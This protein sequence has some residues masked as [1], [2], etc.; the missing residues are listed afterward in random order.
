MVQVKADVRDDGVV[1]H[2]KAPGARRAFGL[3]GRGTRTVPPADWSSVDKRLYEAIAALHRLGDE[4]D[5]AVRF[6]EGAVFADHRAVASLSA[7]AAHLLGLPETVPFVFA[8][9]TAGVI[10]Q[11]SFRLTYDWR[12]GGR[13][14]STRRRGAILDTPAGSF[15]IPEP[16]LSAIELSEAFE[17][18]SVDLPE[19]WAALARFRTKLDPEA[20]TDTEIVP[21]GRDLVRMA[22]ALQQM[23]IF[24]ASAF[25]LALRQ[26]GSNFQF[27]PILFDAETVEARREA[28]VELIEA[29]GVLNSQDTIAFRNDQRSGF[30]AFDQVKRTYRLGQ[31]RYVLLDGDLATV[32]QVVRDK[33][34]AAVEERR[35]F[36]ANPKPAIRE[37][38]EKQASDAGSEPDDDLVEEERIDAAA[39]AVFQETLEYIDRAIGTGLWKK[40]ELGFLP[41]ITSAWMPESFA[42]NL[43]GVWVTV[44]DNKA[45][46]VRQ[47]LIEA[48]ERGD[49]SIEFEG[50]T[51][52][53]TT[54]AVAALDEAVRARTAPPKTEPPPEPVEQTQPD[55]V[56]VLVHEN[57]VEENWNPESQPR[58]SHASDALPPTV[59]TVPMQHQQ[60]AIDWQI[61]AWKA[62]LPGILNAD[63]Q[64]LGKTFQTL[65]FLAWLRANQQSGPPSARKPIL[66]VAPTGLL[67]TWER[68]A[69]SHLAGG[70]LGELVRAYGSSLR[71]LKRHGTS[72][73]DL[74]DGQALLDFGDIEEDLERGFGNRWWVLTSYETL[75]NYQ[76]SFHKLPFA[77]A[78][79][80]EI[81]K[82]KNVQTINANAAKAVVADFRIGLTGT[83]IE[84]HI[85]DL[86][87][88]TDAIVPG[89][90]GTMRE[91]ADRYG[92]VTEAKM[93]ELHARLFTECRSTTRVLPPLAKRRLKEECIGDLP[94]KDYRI[95]PNDMPNM[96]AEVYELA[97]EKLRDGA[98]G[99]ALKLLH[100]IRSV[101]L[102]PRAPRTATN[103]PDA[104]IED[105]ARLKATFE[106]L[107]TIRAASERALVFIEDH[108]MQ[109]RVA[110]MI[111]LRYGLPQVRI[112]NG[113]TA[114]PRRQAHVEAF[115][116]HLVD[117]RG[118]DV[119]VLG[120]KAAGVGL[121]L[122]A[123]THVI[124]L[125]R[126]WNPAVEEQ[127]NDRIY[128]IGQMR[129]VT[130]HLPM[131]VHPARRHQ[132]FDCVLNTLMKRKKSL[133]R[134]VLWPP[135]ENDAD[136]S[137]LIAGLS[138]AEPVDLP[139]IDDKDWLAFEKWLVDEAERSGEWQAAQTPTSG[140]KGADV[141]LTHKQRP[142][143]FGIIQAKHTTVL[144]RLIGDDAV[145]QVL[146]ARKHWRK[147]NPQLAVVT[148]ASGFTEAAQQRARAEDVRLVDRAHLCLW[149]RHIFA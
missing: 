49:P 113:Q 38:L 143:T 35:Q 115:Q 96:Q 61:T 66:I 83:P 44:P 134:A 26:D 63:D 41:K 121:T 5:D 91:F 90:L 17:A 131:A 78:I 87:A 11:A 128:R 114:V 59:Q 100:H 138:G 70:A 99:N 81:Q 29:D 53:A 37:A 56:V 84:N 144:D 9:D 39:E 58:Q 24:T 132:S 82:I 13:S 30:E 139:S 31:G 43:D 40:P 140:D 110:E 8:A 116:R 105:S 108:D 10:G 145:R 95:Y 36:F 118:F 149:P 117:D 20:V 27:D 119:M 142:E 124:H 71:S 85:L 25:S 146:A 107:D 123:A 75:A 89:R 3:I 21:D 92:Q 125:S 6:E 106:I 23:R 147:P 42:A 73:T 80:D 86:W 57:F 67:R 15:R 60:L 47:A 50:V 120:P 69:E 94:R 1:F 93:A 18:G 28:G 2:A 54:A 137:A 111:R 102:H 46:E 16:I 74:L 130:V 55:K 14:V 65:A 72:G 103:D 97:R 7:D 141:I 52:P 32:L 19:H 12:D 127:C 51:I 4:R 22:A 135:T 133:A 112:I 109:Y 136:I 45:G 122:T 79:F 62:G 101:S 88:I 64:G 33:Q 77:V 48:Q 76:H 98:R 34:K 126:W 129:D 68:E 104:Y 148:N